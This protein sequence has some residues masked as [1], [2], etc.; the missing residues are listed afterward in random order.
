MVAVPI[1]LII[2]AEAEADIA[3][4]ALWYQGRDTEAAG[5]SGAGLEQLHLH[6]WRALFPLP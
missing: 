4:A 6:A 1:G 5:T 3:Q 2:R